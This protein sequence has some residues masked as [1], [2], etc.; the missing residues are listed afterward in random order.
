MRQD[1][2]RSTRTRGAEKRPAPTPPAN[3]GE[4][5]KQLVALSS[6]MLS[7]AL[8]PAATVED[9]IGPALALFKEIAASDVEI[10]MM[11]RGDDDIV[12]KTS[13]VQPTLRGELILELLKGPFKEGMHSVPVSAV[14][15]IFGT[16]VAQQNSV[17][18]WHCLPLVDAEK[19]HGLAY[20]GIANLRSFSEDQTDMLN[21]SAERFVTALRFHSRR[22]AL[23]QAVRARDQM[24]SVV[25]H[26]LRNPLNVIGIAAN[27]LLQRFADTSVRS[28]IDRILRSAHRADRMIR[29]LLEIDSI[30]RGRLA[31]ERMVVEPADI[32]LTALDSQQ[33]LAAEASVIIG[34]DLSPQLPR[35]E[36][37]EEHLHR[38]LE[39][40]I[41]NAIKFTHAGGHITVGATA[42]DGELLCWVKDSGIG[43]APEHLPHIFDR[44]YQASRSDRHGTGLGLTI[45]KGIVDAHKGRLWAESTPGTGTTMFF[46]L[47]ATPGES[48]D[49]PAVRANI[50][51][52]DDRP[53][54][55]VALEAILARPDYRLVTA[56]SGEEA[57]SL[58]LREHFAV[59][60][61]DVAMPGMNGLDV[62]VN[63]KAL[64]R[65]R[66]IPII[67][68]TAF[69]NDPEE[70]HR[71]Y[72]AG[73]ADYLV[74][75]L[76]AEIVRK[77]VAVFV[78]LSRRRSSATR[79]SAR[80]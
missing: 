44:F 38:V 70:I 16:E 17:R 48:K 27:T 35:I 34:T 14:Q 69:G 54:N 28:P 73:G 61:I 33:A 72:T 56:T 3:G 65:S 21:A 15:E 39:N 18:V 53:E 6:A 45:C 59:A 76:D 26:D 8:Q 52:V 30:E 67:F 47:P 37:D 5:F 71:A 31:L 23:E 46:A 55:L 75:P 40:L 68:I 10:I 24:L 74:K 20:L 25:A 66:D 60:L 19:L 63:L 57:L 64:E 12:C 78:E 7:G 49:S 22:A 29:D 42:R 4:H 58:S 1:S 62:A 41:G 13:G 32:I 36:A 50:L 80:T 2:S 9:V 43:I 51:L 11:L 77:K 79:A